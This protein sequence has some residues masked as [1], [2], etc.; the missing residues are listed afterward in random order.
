MATLAG[1][2]SR[3]DA[4]TQLTEDE[5]YEN[6]LHASIWLEGPEQRQPPQEDDLAFPRL[7]SRCHIGHYRR[8]ILPHSQLTLEQLLLTDQE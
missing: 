6:L 5:Q 1:T 3:P 4:H 7:R 8:P 2:P